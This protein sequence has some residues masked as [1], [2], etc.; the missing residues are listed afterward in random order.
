MFIGSVCKASQ[1]RSCRF[2]IE[3]FPSPDAVR[4]LEIGGT[5]SRRRGF[6][7]KP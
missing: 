3:S 2:S 7:A 1:I 5:M 4:E 6:N